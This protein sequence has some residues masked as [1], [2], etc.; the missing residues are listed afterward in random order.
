MEGL[1]GKVSTPTYMLLVAGLVMVITLWTSKKARSVI[2]TSLD[3]GRQ[4][5]GGYER[6]S[7]SMVSRSIVRGSVNIAAYL[8]NITPEKWRKN[9]SR[10]FDEQPFLQ[11]QAAQGKEAPAFD[12]VRAS[13]TLIVSSILIAMGTTLKL[14]L[15]TTYVTFMAFMGAS[16][17]DGAWGRESAVYRVTGMLSV[18]GGWFFTALSAFTIAF[19]I[20]VIFYYGGMVAIAIMLIIAAFLI[21]RTHKYHNEK[22]EEEADT[23]LETEETLTKERVVEKSLQRISEIL[24]KYKRLLDNTLQGLA[25]ESLPA[26][27]AASRESGQLYK[28]TVNLRHKATYSLGHLPGND[29]LA[30]QYYILEADYLHEMA[31]SIREIVKSS[32]EHVSNHHKPLL[33]AQIEELNSINDGLKRRFDFIVNT[34]KDYDPDKIPVLKA[35]LQ[36]L[37]KG[38][39]NARKNQ[40]KRIQNKEV[41]TRNSTL[42]LN[43]LGEYRNLALFSSRILRVYEEMIIHGEEEEET[44]PQTPTSP[45]T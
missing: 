44:M 1:A 21:Y 16:L 20:A 7:A 22:L 27:K 34:L 40:I 24:G 5:A 33:P 36:L 39:Q 32:L 45:G 42:F 11:K 26:L 30:G 43:Y 15:S 29:L 18:V 13:V 10:Q 2:K 12:M 23:G 4:D 25:Q 41:G 38:I 3:L 8:E 31:L 35:E 17:A 9:L 37:I 19:I 14:P 28:K 6:F